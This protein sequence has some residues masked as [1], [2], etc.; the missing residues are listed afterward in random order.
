MIG[1]IKEIEIA[2]VQRYKTNYI[3]TDEEDRGEDN[4]LQSDFE[5]FN[6]KFS[7]RTKRRIK[8]N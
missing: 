8:R 4:V 2:E 6:L 7:P 1:K 3:I 5:A